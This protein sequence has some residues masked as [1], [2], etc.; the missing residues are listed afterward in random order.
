[1]ANVIAG[2]AVSGP[3]REGIKYDQTQSQARQ[4]GHIRGCHYQE[5]LQI[6]SD[7]VH[8]FMNLCGGIIGSFPSDSF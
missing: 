1:M 4:M 7:G 8:G 6:H 2:I 5:I 3:G